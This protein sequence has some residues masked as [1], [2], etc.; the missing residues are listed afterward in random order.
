[1]T[2]DEKLETVYRLFRWANHVGE[3]GAEMR[4]EDIEGIFAAHAPMILNGRP[5]CHDHASHF[6]HAQDLRAQMATWRFNIPF[7]R[8]VVE[9]DQVVGYYTVD[10]TDHAGARGRFY[11]LCIFTVRDDRIAGILETVHFEGEALDIASFD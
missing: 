5:I 10:F 4:L 3:T 6:R 11:D 8:T 2:R 9:G 7:E 1:M